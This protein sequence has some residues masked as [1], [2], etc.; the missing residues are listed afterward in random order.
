MILVV[1]KTGNGRRKHYS[2]RDES[3]RAEAGVRRHQILQAANCHTYPPA[4]GQGTRE[5]ADTPLMALRYPALSSRFFIALFVLLASLVG[6][7][8]VSM[9][10]LRD[11]QDA[12]NQVFSDNYLTAQDTS[13]LAIELGARREPE[14]AHRRRADAATATELRTQLDQVVIPKVNTL[15]ATFV[16]I[17][18]DDPPAELRTI[19]RITPEWRA[20]LDLREHGGL[21]GSY[22]AVPRS[23]RATPARSP[24]RSIRS[25][26]SSPGCSR[27]SR[28]RR[29]RAHADAT[30]VFHRSELWLLVAG[31]DRARRRRRDGAHR[32]DAAAPRR[33]AVDR[34]ELRRGR[35]RV[36]RH[37]AGDRERGRGAG[38]AAPARRALAD[39]RA[40]RRARTATTAP[41][42]SSRRP[43]SPSSTACASRSA[44]RPRARASRCASGARTPRAA[45]RRP[46]LELRDLRRAA[47]R[48]TLRAAARR[49]R[50]H[51]LGAD[52]R[53]R[54]SRTSATAGACARRSA[55]RRPCSPTSATS[56]SRSCA[57][58]PT[59]SPG[60]RTS[61]RCRTRSSA[62]SPRPRA[63]SAR[64][65]RCCSTSTTSSRSTTP[66]ATIAATR[67]SPRSASRCATSSATSDFVG[68]Y[69]GEEFLVLLPAT[70]HEGAVRLAEKRPRARSRRSRSPA[71]TIRSRRASASPSLP[72]DGG[73]AVDALPLGRPR[74][75]RRQAQR[76]RSSRDRVGDRRRAGCRSRL[77]VRVRVGAPPTSRT[78]NRD[79]ASGRRY[80]R[81]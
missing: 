73:D 58:R 43:R 32:A 20:F 10:G 16:E 53:S 38:A 61:A 6:V 64:S 24:R 33:A 74:A 11:V 4:T 26:R 17:H 9:H 12:N 70:D 76:P 41:I 47:G 60:S 13:N 2:H 42:G 18:A 51:R 46:L 30:A 80:V 79:L 59:R 14:P 62:W 34:G 3:R 67:C 44:A 23:A 77:T 71:S 25:P 69:G 37:A 72:Q 39:G 49:R 36:H 15:I 7:G 40:R 45:R 29:P 27:S 57:P 54:R 56:R 65:R 48:S 5:G 66:T 21:P 68:R 31:A 75:L 78:P 8:V 19:S 52:R 22:P 63:R 1:P 28:T 81:R 50:G 55:R 35:G